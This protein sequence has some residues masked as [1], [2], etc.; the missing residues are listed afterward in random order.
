MNF[1]A[2]Y[3][4]KKLWEKYE[5]AD[6]VKSKIPAILDWI[7]RDVKTILD[8]GCGNG[9]ITN[10]L[11]EK[12]DVTGTDYSASALEFVKGKKVLASADH[13][14]FKDRSFDLVFSSEML[15][16]LPEE[17][18]RAAIDEMRRITKGY[19]F[20]TVPNRE[21]LPKN[22]IKCPQCGT[23]F[24]VYGHL[25]SF[26]IQALD[27]LVGPSFKRYMVR[28]FG[29]KEKNYQPLLLKI[30]QHIANR[31]FE[32]TENTICPQ[33]SN[34]EFPKQKGNLLSKLCNGLNFLISG[35]REYWLFAFYDRKEY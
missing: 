35:K 23:I 11:A 20:L 10:A 25:H 33:C 12:Y 26:D 15:E 17:V 30:R 27:D 5:Q 21:Y 16:H 3:Q 6:L 31:W 1:D 19:L 32:A 2:M 8:V 7:P 18:L 34:T 24:H 29:P 14:P 9:I 22:Y 13:L 4:N 28:T